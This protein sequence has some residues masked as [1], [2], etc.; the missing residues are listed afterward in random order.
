M[1]DKMVYEAGKGDRYRKVDQEK[2]ASNY[3]LIFGKKNENC[4]SEKRTVA[5]A[6]SKTDKPTTRQSE[7]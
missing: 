1:T 4:S 7:D 6:R 2:F 5:Q 3:D